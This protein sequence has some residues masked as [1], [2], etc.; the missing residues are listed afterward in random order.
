MLDTETLPFPIPFLIHPSASDLILASRSALS[1][2]YYAS[3]SRPGYAFTRNRVRKTELGMIAMTQWW[4][5]E[6][7]SR[8]WRPPRSWP[9]NRIRSGLRGLVRGRA[10]FVEAEPASPAGLGHQV[11][12]RHLHALLRRGWKI[13]CHDGVGASGLTLHTSPEFACKKCSAAGET[14][15]FAFAPVFRQPRSAGRCIS[16]IRD[17]GR[18]VP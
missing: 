16:G 1:S 14:A 18:L 17:A 13:S 12:R 6:V 3:G 9:A 4:R 11:T 8:D 7:T 15:L 5:P 10:D 2:A